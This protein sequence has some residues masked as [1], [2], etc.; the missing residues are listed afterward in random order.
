MFHLPSLPGK[1][2]LL[3]RQEDARRPK[4]MVDDR[5]ILLLIGRGIMDHQPEAIRKRNRLVHAVPAM[6]LVSPI[7][8]MPTLLDEVT[9]VRCRVEKNI[10]RAHLHTA[11]DARLQ[12]FIFGLAVLKGKI[13][14]IDDEPFRRKPPQRS[15]DVRQF[16][17]LRFCQLDEAQP[18][19]EKLIGQRFR[20]G[21]FSRS[22]GPHQKDIVR[23][24]AAEKCQSIA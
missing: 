16:Y 22:P 23:R 3:R 14:Q 5:Q 13:V 6:Y 8:V 24:T 12:G 1:A 4:I 7:A 19:I 18:L 11:F 9:A 10:I 17:Q 20:R 21:R 15:H 2:Q